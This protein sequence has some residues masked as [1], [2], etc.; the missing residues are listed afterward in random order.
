MGIGLDLIAEELLELFS[1]QTKK[2]RYFGKPV[3]EVAFECA[4]PDDSN[5][6]AAGAGCATMSEGPS[7]ATNN[8]GADCALVPSAQSPTRVSIAMSRAATRDWSRP[9]IPKRPY[10]RGVAPVFTDRSHPPTC[11]AT[12]T[13]K[14]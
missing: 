9:G 1:Q 13:I 8:C 14:A 4:S 7:V 5:L 11:G 6:V 10:S 12:D 3:C 2:V